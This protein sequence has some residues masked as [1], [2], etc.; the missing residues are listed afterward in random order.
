MREFRPQ[1]AG[2][3]EDWSESL[4]FNFHDKEAGLTAFMR[5]G[6]KP[7]RG[8]KEAFLFVMTD[9]MVCGMRTAAEME[10]RPL[11]VNGLSYEREGDAWRIAYQGQL[12]YMTEDGPIPIEA[13]LDVLWTPLNEEFDYRRCVDQRSERLAAAVA[14]EHL[15]QYGEAVGALSLGGERHRIRGLG[16]RDH[17]WG[18]RDWNAPREWM[19]INCH[20]DRRTSLNLTRL[21]VDQGEVVAGFVHRDGVSHPIKRAKVETKYT[22]KGGPA[23]F[24]LDISEEGGKRHILGA[25]VVREAVLPFEKDGARSLLFETLAEYD[26]KGG[27]GYGI[28]EY[29]IRL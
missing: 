9:R 13:D 24:D 2:E 8:Q 12:A 14:S 28:A 27:T 3:G 20:L 21:V 7:N 1:E 15:E 19:W 29:L 4:Y 26:W 23:S 17:S 5:I 22:P 18:V 16:E 11:E 6:L 10:G 25:K